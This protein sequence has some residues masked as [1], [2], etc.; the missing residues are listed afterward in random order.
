MVVPQGVKIKAVTYE[1]LILE[2]V[3]KH[4][5]QNMFGGGPF[6]FQQDGA[7]AHTANKTQK[8]LQENVP[9]FL[10]KDEWPPSSPDLNP[11]DFCVWSVLESNACAKAHRSVEALKLTLEREWAKIPMDTLHAAVHAVPK[12][13]KAVIRKRGGF[14]E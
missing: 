4:L 8:W 11:M 5:S 1:E 3:V 14:I 7:P 12:R 6:L 13:L 2:P 9:D 10:S